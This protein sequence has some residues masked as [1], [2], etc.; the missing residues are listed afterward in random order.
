MKK[1]SILLFFSFLVL[2]QLV[3]ASLEVTKTDKNNVVISELNNPVTFDLTFNNTERQEVELFSFVGV[4]FN[5]SKFANLS[6]GTSTFPV[7]ATL[8]K[9]ISRRDDYYN[10][11]YVVSSYKSGAEKKFMQVYVVKAKE[12]ILFDALDFILGDEQIKIGVTNN[13]NTT[14]EDLNF[15]FSSI[16]F[17]E[18]K[19][20]TLG[21]RETKLVNLNVNKE[22]ISSINAGSYVFTV[23]LTGD[24]VTADF[25]GNIDYKEKQDTFLTKK[26]EGFLV[27]KVTITQTNKGNIPVDGLIEVKKDIF[28]RLFTVNSI[29]PLSIERS[30]LSATYLWNKNLKPGESYSVTSTTNYTFPFILILLIVI[31]VL[32]VNMYTR[33]NLVVNKRVSFVKTRGGEFALKVRIH[34]KAKKYVENIQLIDKLPGMTQLYEKF[35]IAPDKIDK[36]TRRMFWNVDRLNAGEERVYSYIIFS[37]VNI[38]GRFELPAASA[39]Y[40]RDGKSEQTFSNRAFFVAENTVSI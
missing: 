26:N 23:E 24:N 7:E 30:A 16:F 21:P 4:T 1:S 11:E 38:V 20:I 8:S 27:R 5:P 39:M 22:I 25:K 15:K 17:D 10:I 13:L 32:L 9:S 3:S 19:S 34:V 18:S 28:S 37:K 33:T 12:V 2:L 31:I 35:G 36:P 6:V 40:T 14:L 29:E